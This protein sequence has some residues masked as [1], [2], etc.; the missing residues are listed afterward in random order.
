MISKEKECRIKAE[1]LLEEALYFINQIPRSKQTNSF[2]DS[3]ELAS[4]IEFLLNEI[5][6]GIY[7]TRKEN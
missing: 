4:K 2:R 6:I 1:F 3:Y 5:K 7:D